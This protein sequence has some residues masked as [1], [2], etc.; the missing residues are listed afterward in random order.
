MMFGTESSNVARA[1]WFSSFYKI[2]I[3]HFEVLIFFLKKMNLDVG[4]DVLY[5]CAKSQDEIH[6]I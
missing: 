3:Q 4:N 2:R 5:Y 1:T 6:Y